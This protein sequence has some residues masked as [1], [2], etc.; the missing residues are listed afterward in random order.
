MRVRMR[1]VADVHELTADSAKPLRAVAANCIGL[2]TQFVQGDKFLVRSD[3]LESECGSKLLIRV[4]SI[5]CNGYWPNHADLR[6][7]PGSSMASPVEAIACTMIEVG[8][9]DGEIVKALGAADLY[10]EQEVHDW[11]QAALARLKAREQQHGLHVCLSDLFVPGGGLR[12]LYTFNH[13]KRARHGCAH[14]AEPQAVRA[15][16]RAATP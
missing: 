10:T 7:L 2:L 15:G 14:G 6:T 13:P 12:E 5:H 3:E 16:F 4:P 1:Y 8:A 9:A 11:A